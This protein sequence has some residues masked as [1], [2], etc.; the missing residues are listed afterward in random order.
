M[1]CQ[2]SNHDETSSSSST[3]K[4]MR[5]PRVCVFGKFVIAKPFKAVVTNYYYLVS[6]R[7]KLPHRV[8]SLT[9]WRGDIGYTP[10]GGGRREVTEFA[11][12]YNSLYNNLGY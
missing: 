10:R 5:F 11:A 3:T 8:T 2:L 12:C 1:E 9:F 4:E 7:I 6:M